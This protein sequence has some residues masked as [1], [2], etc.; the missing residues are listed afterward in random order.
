MAEDLEADRFFARRMFRQWPQFELVAQLENG[1]EVTA[2][3]LGQGIYE[4]RD[5]FPLPDVLLLDLKMPRKNGIEVLKWLHAHGFGELIVVIL[6]YSV[7]DT[8]ME[9]CMRLGVA[10]Y[11]TKTASVE[12]EKELPRNLLGLLEARELSGRPAASVNP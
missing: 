2:Y 8:D 3:L 7:L 9:E 10:A 5:V 1:E 11:H 4:N 12:I 6:T